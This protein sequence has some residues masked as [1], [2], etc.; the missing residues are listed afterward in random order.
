MI[1]RCE[2]LLSGW[3]EIAAYLDRSVRT[4]QR[5]AR[6]KG[7]PVTWPAGTRSTPCASK[8][9]LRAWALGEEAFHSPAN[10]RERQE[11][12]RAVACGS[13]SLLHSPEAMP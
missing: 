8:A 4:V 6:H 2:E 12:P 13:D 3:K 11:S 9:A 5:W 7:L 10:M 1:G